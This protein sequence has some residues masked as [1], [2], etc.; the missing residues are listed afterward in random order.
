MGYVVWV[1]IVWIISALVASAEAPRGRAAEFFVITL[2]FLGPLGV[3]FAAI[4]TP[5]EAGT[6][7]GVATPRETEMPDGV[8]TPRETE[9][10]D[11]VDAEQRSGKGWFF[12]GLKGEWD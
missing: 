1:L 5:R 9:M 10:P 8:A 12:R 4:A 2:L 7:D 11:G 6:P 3:G